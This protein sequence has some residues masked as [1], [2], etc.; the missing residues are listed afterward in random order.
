MID[1]IKEYWILLIDL[2]IPIFYII[3]TLL[4]EGKLETLFP[5]TKQ[6]PMNSIIFVAIICAILSIAKIIF[7]FKRKNHK[8]LLDK[9]EKENEFLKNLISDFKYQISQPLEDELCKIFRLLKLDTNYRI[10]VYTYTSE[11]FFSIARYAENPNLKKFGRIAISN[12]E[13]MIFQAWNSGEM[14]KK[15]SS[16]NKR[17]MKSVKISIKYLYEKNDSNPKKDRFG[18]I[19]FETTKNKENKIDLEN[20]DKVTQ[21][22]QDFFDNNWNI[23]QNLTTAYKEGL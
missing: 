22:I 20:L 6:H 17:N 10:T 9:A 14:T 4:I 18:I 19:V 15:I 21:Q 3:L 5:Y 23:K 16:D 8:N 11:I 2:F 1:K 13:E 12:K 7:E